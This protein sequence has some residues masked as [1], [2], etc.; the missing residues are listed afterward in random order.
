MFAAGDVTERQEIKLAGG[1]M[2][3]GLVA[4][5]NI[6]SSLL[7]EAGKRSRAVMTACPPVYLQAKMD[8][9]VGSN[10]VSSS[11]GP[12]DTPLREGKDR[13]QVVFGGH[14]G[15]QRKSSRFQFVDRMLC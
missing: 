11:G 14:L 15:W 7:F 1:A 4:A 10:V 3:M 5:V 9:S 6:Y 8:L 13:D 2:I 12:D